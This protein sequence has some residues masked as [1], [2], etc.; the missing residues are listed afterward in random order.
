MNEFENDYEPFI[1]VNIEGDYYDT[2][3]TDLLFISQIL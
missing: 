2:E 3:D 1:E